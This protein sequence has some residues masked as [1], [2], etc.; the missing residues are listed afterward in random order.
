MGGPKDR[1]TKPPN[2]FHRF[3]FDGQ[4]KEMLASASRDNDRPMG[5]QFLIG[6]T[7]QPVPAIMVM[8]IRTST[9][10]K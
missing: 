3:L 8:T 7:G 1:P 6:N 2:L 4:T 5:G 10:I 9:S